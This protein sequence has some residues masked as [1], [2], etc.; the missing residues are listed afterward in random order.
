MRLRSGL[1]RSESL[2]PTDVARAASLRSLSCLGAPSLRLLQNSFPLSFPPTRPPAPH[3]GRHLKQAG[4]CLGLERG[5][6]ERSPLRARSLR[7]G[8]LRG[9]A[10]RGLRSLL[11]SPRC[12]GSPLKIHSSYES[13]TRFLREILQSKKSAEILIP[14]RLK[15]IIFGGLRS[16]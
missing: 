11:R 12:P 6:Q 16:G 14:K 9:A 7:S 4:A 15:L 3:F 10:L 8:L 13:P 1:S 2:R 5:A